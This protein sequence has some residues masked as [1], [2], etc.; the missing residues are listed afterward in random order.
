M[1]LRFGLSP[2]KRSEAYFVDGAVKTLV[3]VQT[4]RVFHAG[5]LGSELYIATLSIED[6]FLATGCTCPVGGDCKHAYAALK[7]LLVEHT[8]AL[9]AD[10][11]SMNGRKKLVAKTRLAPGEFSWRV[12]EKPGCEPARTRRA[13]STT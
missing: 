6:E 3:C 11:S 13:I 12:R 5:V 8:A 4:G 1:F 10:L 9:V 7:Q 2:W